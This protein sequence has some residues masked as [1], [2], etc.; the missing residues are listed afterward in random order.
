MARP[1]SFGARHLSGASVPSARIVVRRL[2]RG[3]G[4]SLGRKCFFR[5]L[6][7]RGS[8]ALDQ[9][10]GALG[11]RE[12]SPVV[13]STS[14]RVF[15]GNLR[16]QFY[17]HCLPEEPRR[18]T[19][20]SSELHRSEDSPLGGE[21]SGCDFSPVYYGKTQRSRGFFISL[22]SD[23]GL[24]MDSEA[25]GLS[26]SVQEVA[27]VDRSICNITKSPMFDIFFSLPRSQRS[28]NG[29][30]SSE[31]EWVAGV[32]LSSLV[33]HS[34]SSEKA[35]VALWGPADHHS[36]V[37]APEAVVSGSSRSGGRRSG[38]SSAVQGSSA[39]APL[40]SV[41]SGG[42]Q[43]VPSCLETIK[44]FTRAGGFSKHV[45]QQVSLARC[46]SSRAGY[47]SKWLVFRQWCRSEGHSISRPSL[48]KIADFLF[49]LRRSCRLSVSAVM[50]YRSMLSAVF[51]SILP[52][53][54]SSPVLHD[55]LRSFQVEAPVREV[56]PP[57]WDL[58]LVL[59]FLRSSPFEPLSSA[60]LRDLTRKTLLLLSL[61]TAKGVGELQA[62]SRRVSFSSSSAGLS[63]VP[64]FVAKTETATRPLPRSFEVQSLEDFAAGLPEDLLLCPVRSLSAYL[65]RTSNIANRPR[66]LFVSPKCPSRAM[67]KNGISYMLREL[68]VQSSAS[69]QSG[70]APRAHSIRGMATSS[71]FF[72]IGP[73]VAFW[74]RPLGVRTWFL[75]LFICRIYLLI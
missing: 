14:R 71:A 70:Q 37:L 59:N 38:L 34:S 50:G 47:Q 67:S 43:A 13:C 65:A 3:L 21:S 7:S 52:E 11:H 25:G 44:R 66:R 20:L 5:P 63:Y 61:T 46:P 68:I 75:H 53:I 32:C 58:P 73:F 22:K 55:L 12:S 54:S 56:R 51:K 72:G 64:E 36:S 35:P 27:G 39:S 2:G 9:R 29:C 62:M 45:A 41:S 31:L 28:G 15:G 30:S 40:P 33:P 23:S 42:I 49:W 48:S 17:G 4:D 19:F 74:R 1:R 24:R 18:D 10:Q 8:R 69:S 16:R 57:S 26:G 60:S 6:G